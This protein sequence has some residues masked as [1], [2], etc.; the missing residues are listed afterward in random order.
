MRK[1]QIRQEKEKIRNMS[2]KTAA[3]YI[4]DY[5]KIWIIAAVVLAGL[6]VYFIS[7]YRNRPP[8]EIWKVAF[9]NFYDDVSQESDF[10]QNFV[11]SLEI[12]AEE[13]S[14]VFD[15]N[16][17]FN[18]E[19]NSD[20]YNTYYQ[21]LIAYLEAGTVDCVICEYA[22]LTGIGR[23]GRFLDLSDDRTASVYERYYDRMVWIT[24]E[25]G[26]FPI[27]IDISDSPVL[28][29][30]NGYTDGC[31]LAISSNMAHMEL[32]DEFLAYLLGD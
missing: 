27:G 5:Y 22:N 2:A 23:T 17:F 28:T 31:Y 32:I 8:E 20:Y 18:L 14:I 6:L 4:W 26:E 15:N 3:R 25:E 24:T 16:L 29:R 13:G 9:V 21:R 11:E 10:S 19:R 30:M 7:V 1:E 12:P